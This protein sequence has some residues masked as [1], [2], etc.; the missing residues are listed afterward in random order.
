MM[1]GKVDTRAVDR[2]LEALA[3]KSGRVLPHIL[4]EFG[5][6]I[7]RDLKAHQR[8]Q[9]G[10]DGPWP[11]LSPAT[12]RKRRRAKRGKGGSRRP[13][14]KLPTL[15]TARIVDGEAIQVR[16]RP[17]VAKLAAAHDQG[18][19]VGHGARLPARE[20]FYVSDELLDDFE[21]AV[22]GSLTEIWEAV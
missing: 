2:G 7:R 18:A 21:R 10:P 3:V 6:H 4:G 1:D 8:T 22:V 16:P 11:K 5:K 19:V 9:S 13:L 17:Q 12:V 14:G 20:W 15:V